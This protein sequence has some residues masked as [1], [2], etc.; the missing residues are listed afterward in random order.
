MARYAKPFKMYVSTTMSREDIEEGWK[1]AAA[2][3]RT[4]HKEWPE[5][6]YKAKAPV[7][8]RD[9]G[10]SLKQEYGMLPGET[11]QIYWNRVREEILNKY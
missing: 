8:H 11:S 6:Y 1:R 4:E 2:E 7:D 9:H 3:Y 5:W 10:K